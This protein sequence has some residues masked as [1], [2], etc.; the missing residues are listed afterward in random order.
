MLFRSLVKPSYTIANI[1]KFLDSISGYGA[2]NIGFEDVG[3]SLAGDYNPKAS[4]SREASMNMQVGKL[5][6]LKE[7]GSRVMTT[8][9]NQ[10]AV[11]YSDY[12]TDVNID[13]KAVNIIDE[14]VPFYAIAL[15]GLVNFSGSAINLS[16]DETDMILKSAETGAGLYY[17]FM[18]A[19]TSVLQ[20]TDYTQYYACSFMDWKDSAIGLYNRFNTELGDVYSQ[21]ISSHEKLANGVYKTT[22]E[23]GKVVLVNYNYAD[24]D[25]NG[26]T[27]P[28]RE[29]VTLKQEV[30]NK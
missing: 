18:N 12:V 26:T 16:E 28:K 4:V 17:T 25:Y 6:S 10:Y 1:D 24:Y 15:H 23:S 27:V 13:P 19:P 3:N 29:F 21:F 14:S 7:S 8:S 30:D 20:D 2:L 9:G 11:P 5:K 22:Y